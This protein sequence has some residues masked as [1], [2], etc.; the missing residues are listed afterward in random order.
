MTAEDDIASLV[1]LVRTIA[2]ESGNPEGIDFPK[3]VRAWLSEP[4]PALG[5]RPP[6]VL[7]SEPG[8]LDAVQGLLRRWQS[9]A[10]S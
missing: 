10:Y 3:F 9:G 4:H 7:L 1:A 2:E 8:G 5:G 6:R